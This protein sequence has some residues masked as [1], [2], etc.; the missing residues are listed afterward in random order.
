[1]A[2]RHPETGTSSARETLFVEQF[3]DFDAQRL[4][5]LFG[6]HDGGYSCGPFNLRHESPVHAGLVRQLFLRPA[7]LASQRLHA[8]GQ[9]FLDLHGPD[10]GLGAALS[11]T[12]YSSR[13][14]LLGWDFHGSSWSWR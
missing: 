2:R 9:S 5:K 14:D 1:M 11:S 6:S 13:F 7:L 12:A 4:R 10:R 8:R 3:A